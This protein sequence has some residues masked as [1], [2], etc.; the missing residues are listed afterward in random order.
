[1]ELSSSWLFHSWDHHKSDPGSILRSALPDGDRAKADHQP[2][3]ELSYAILPIIALGNTPSSGLDGQCYSMRK[4]RSV[5]LHSAC[6]DGANPGNSVK[7]VSI[8]LKY[9]LEL[10]PDF[11]VSMSILERTERKSR[12]LIKRL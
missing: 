1:M 3:T 8:L 6:A 10:V 12:L 9:L 4:Q 5:R 2:L 7:C 11:S